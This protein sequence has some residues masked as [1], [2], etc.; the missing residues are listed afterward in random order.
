MT[1]RGLRNTRGQSEVLGFVLVFAIV[2][3]AIG[4]VT[5]TGFAGLQHAKHV[6]EA[7]NGARAFEIFGDNVNDI[8]LGRAPHRST[9]IKLVDSRLALGAPVHVNVS[10]ERIGDPAANFTESYSVRPVLYDVGDGT[11]H[12]YEGGAVIR[13][14]RGGVIML[15]EPAFILSE[16]ESVIP[17]VNVRPKH[18]DSSSVGGTGTFDVRTHLTSTELLAAETVPYHL[19]MEITSPRAAA[20]ER[21]FRDLDC[22]SVTRV[23]DTVTCDIDSQRVYVTVVNV[24]V[25][26]E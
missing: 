7:N 12:V 20:W 18:L 10:G 22:G 26:F 19:E 21:Y 14:E 8:V 5:A 11:T 3:T 4:L 16:N 23:T 24:D 9:E 15:R 25:E 17:I 1:D 2:V 6:D 13:Q